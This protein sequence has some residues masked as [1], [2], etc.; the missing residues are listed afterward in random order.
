MK[1]RRSNEVD[2]LFTGSEV[3]YCYKKSVEICFYP[4]ISS[5]NSTIWSHNNDVI[6]HSP[7]TD[8]KLQT[9]SIKFKWRN[10]IKL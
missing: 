1:F 2:L 3:T 6:S 9:S 8:I 5:N 7:S 4:D 10:S